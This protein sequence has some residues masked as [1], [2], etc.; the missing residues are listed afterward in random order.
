MGRECL[1]DGGV[2]MRSWGGG[3]RDWERI[4]EMIGKGTVNGE[5]EG[6]EG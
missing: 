6:K 3:M 1:T 5:E 4:G 2:G